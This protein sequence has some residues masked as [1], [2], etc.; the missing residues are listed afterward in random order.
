MN[1]GI[2]LE[3]P[4]QFAVDGVEE[5]LVVEA[6]EADVEGFAREEDLGAAGEVLAAGVGAEVEELL[7]GMGDEAELGA[8][9]DDDGSEGEVVGADGRDDEAAAI[10][11]EDGAAAAEG[12]GGGAGGGGDDEA[13]AGVGGH[14]VAI[15][16]E[17]GAQEGAVVEAVEADLV[18]GE[19]GELLA[20]GLVVGTGGDVEEGAGLEGVAAGEEVGDEG[21]H[22]VAA[23]GGEEAEMAEVDAD[24]GDLATSDEVDGA[25]E[26]AVATD[27]EKEVARAF[28][29]GVDD[30]FGFDTVAVEDV[31]EGLELLPGLLFEITDIEGDGHNRFKN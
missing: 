12:V 11:C 7:L 27:G 3:A 25:E 15:D 21:V 26:G 4:A 16:V 2:H 28:G 9:G 5:G 8:V 24:D 20:D 17:V 31:G 10:G 1:R 14:E 29:E 19:G 13:V 18:E 6:D 30:L 23:G 22:I